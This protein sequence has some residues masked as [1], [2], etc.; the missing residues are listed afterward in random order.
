MPENINV[1]AMS[2]RLALFL[3][4]SLF[5]IDSSDERVR[6]QYERTCFSS[7]L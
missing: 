1:R 6:E 4:L 3:S 5:L 7:F 2:Q